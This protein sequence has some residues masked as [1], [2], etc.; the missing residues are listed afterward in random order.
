MDR[1]NAEGCLV[2][3]V[4]A[5]TSS[6]ALTCTKGQTRAVHCCCPWC[7]PKHG[8]GHI[9]S[10]VAALCVHPA[11]SELVELLMKDEVDRWVHGIVGH[12]AALST[13]VC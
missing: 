7:Q 1:V 5:R 9:A 13:P 4:P 6:G 2:L 10:S 12:G 8:D 11:H 3:R